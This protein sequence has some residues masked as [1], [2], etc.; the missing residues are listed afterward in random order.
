[1]ERATHR[2]VAWNGA[3]LLRCSV[4]HSE[5]HT[6]IPRSGHESPIPAFPLPKLRPLLL[7][8][9]IVRRGEDLLQ[10]RPGRI[11]CELAFDRICWR[12]PALGW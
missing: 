7:S 3:F 11:S 8:L 1:V 5:G 6:R 2:I 12:L 10:E 4:Y 9:P